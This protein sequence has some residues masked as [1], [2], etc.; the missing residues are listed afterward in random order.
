MDEQRR[1]IAIVSFSPIHR[2]ARVLRQIQYASNEFDVLVVGYGEWPYSWPNVRFFGIRRS[3]PRLVKNPVR[4]FS[5]IAGMV[6]APLWERTYWRK[7]ENQIAR[8]YLIQN[9]V[10]LIHA[11]DLIALPLAIDVAKIIKCKVLFDAHEY[12]LDETSDSVSGRRMRLAYLRYLLE[13]YGPQADKLITVSEGIANVYKQEFQ[14]DAG[15]ILNVPRRFQTTPSKVNPGDIK[16][17]HHGI[18]AAGRNLESLVKMV[19]F[20]DERYSLY[21]M[22]VD[23]SGKILARLDRLAHGLQQNRVFFLAPVDPDEIVESISKFDI[24]VF[25]LPA[26]CINHKYTLPNKFFDYISAGLAVGIGP[27]PEMASIVT[28]Y[29]L[30]VIS[31]TFQAEDFAARLNRLSS[32]EI[33]MMKSKSVIASEEFNADIEMGKLM[34]IYRE[35]IYAHE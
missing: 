29:D 19:G 20:L 8:D 5:L 11:N 6:Y 24:G 4:A 22:L 9:Q 12:Y 13:K 7:E 16:L 25:V 27:S 32:D 35:L 26:D 15:V 2:D 28:N 23:Y 3:D 17:I 33:F 10:D 34:H 31:D 21:L 1:R 18:A 14:L 30:G